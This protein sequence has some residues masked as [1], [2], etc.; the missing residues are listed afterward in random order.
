[1]T[2]HPDVSGVVLKVSE[3]IYLAD[4]VNR[5]L[6]SNNPNEILAIAEN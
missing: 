3:L 4:L 1:M 6:S 2:D 5:A